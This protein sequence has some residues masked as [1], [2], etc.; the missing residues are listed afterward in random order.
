MADI[1]LPITERE[2]YEADLEYKDSS[3]TVGALTTTDT[4]KVDN[5]GRVLF[6]VK[7]GTG[8]G[9]IVFETT[10]EVDGL[11]VTDRTIALT[12][13]NDVVLGPFPP[14]VYNDDSGKLS[15]TFSSVSNLEIAAF[16]G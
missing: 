11:S 8:T 7:K 4:F 15:I 14:N 12:A 10:A 6:L 3:S 13:N 2:A 16:R 1:N 9:N 5:D